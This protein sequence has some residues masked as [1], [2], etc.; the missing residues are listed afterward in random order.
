ME[1]SEREPRVRLLTKS[2]CHL[3]AAARDTVESV[4][5][6]HGV[7]WDEVLIDHDPE[8]LRRFGEEVP[9]LLVDGLQRDF[10]VIDPV[11]LEKLIGA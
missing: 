7:A 5:R 8:L 11:R 2:G 9:V 10:W 1:S 3:C 4:T 6:K